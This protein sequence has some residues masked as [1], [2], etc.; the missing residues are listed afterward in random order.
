MSLS[1]WKPLIA[2]LAATVVLVGSAAAWDVLT[3]YGSANLGINSGD[4]QSPS[5]ANL[6]GTATSGQNLEQGGKLY[7]DLQALFH[8]W[9]DIGASGIIT[10]STAPDSSDRTKS[11]D[12][13]PNFSAQIKTVDPNIFDANLGQSATIGFL[14]LNAN[15]AIPTFSGDAQ[16]WASFTAYNPGEDVKNIEISFANKQ[17][18]SLISETK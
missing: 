9:V 10:A 1:K 5:G 7:D 3:Q 12:I 6:F 8:N 16:N 15:D 14:R 2:L 13:D 18:F 17:D 4:L 11:G